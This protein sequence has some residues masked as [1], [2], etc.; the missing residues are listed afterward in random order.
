M[1]GLARTTDQGVLDL[2][3]VSNASGKRVCE[4]T[5]IRGHPFAV[6]QPDD[7]GTALLVVLIKR[8]RR[9]RD[10]GAPLNTVLRTG[11][12]LFTSN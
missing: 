11:T 12:M 10:Y 9:Q 3:T 5:P 7:R 4:G 6:P 8:L 1:I 2:D